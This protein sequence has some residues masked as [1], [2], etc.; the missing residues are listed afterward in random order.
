[1]ALVERGVFKRVS[2]RSCMQIPQTR[3]SLC[4]LMLLVVGLA[5]AP[6]DAYAAGLPRAESREPA[7]E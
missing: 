6:A 5:N 3:P 2:A 7:R 4:L 1:M